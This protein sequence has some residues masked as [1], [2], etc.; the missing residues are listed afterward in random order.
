[1][2][3]NPLTS[4]RSASSANYAHQSLSAIITRR[5][6]GGD[7]GGRGAIGLCKA[8]WTQDLGTDLSL[9]SVAGFRGSEVIAR[10]IHRSDS[11]WSSFAFVDRVV[12]FVCPNS[13][14]P[15]PQGRPGGPRRSAR[16]SSTRWWV[17]P[18][19]RPIGC[20]GSQAKGCRDASNPHL[21]PPLNS[22]PGSCNGHGPIGAPLPNWPK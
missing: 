19:Q 6:F 14:R 21:P 7:G 16:W 1:M 10:H 22:G 20:E 13:L 17:P 3:P 4:L 5:A 18:A 11:L 9:R 12:G 15:P 2:Y 8:K